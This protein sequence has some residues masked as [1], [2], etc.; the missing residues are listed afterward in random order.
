MVRGHDHCD[1]CRHD[2]ARSSFAGNDNCPPEKA[3]RVRDVLTMTSMVMMYKEEGLPGFLQRKTSYPTVARYNPRA[4]KPDVFTVVFDSAAA[5]QYC[6]E[7]R[8]PILVE[9]ARI[10]VGRKTSVETDRTRMRAEQESVENE[11]KKLREQLVELDKA[12]V[13][14][15]KAL[16]LWKKEKEKIES[17]P[18]ADTKRILAMREKIKAKQEQLAERKQNREEREHLE[19]RGEITTTRLDDLGDAM[20]RLRQRMLGNTDDDIQADIEELQEEI[21]QEQKSVKN[22]DPDLLNAR[23]Q[24]EAASKALDENRQRQA[25]A[26]AKLKDREKRQAEIISELNK[27]NDNLARCN[28]AERLLQKEVK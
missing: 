17:R 3:A 13:E 15:E 26:Q 19:R 20:T 24:M 25:Q 11:L 28:E 23:D 6:D 1:L 9:Q 18:I 2:W 21:R 7:A 16:S 22:K 14:S 27:I 5:L 12:V 10:I 8:K 4:V